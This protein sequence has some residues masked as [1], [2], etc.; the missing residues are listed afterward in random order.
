MRCGEVGLACMHALPPARQVQ[1]HAQV[2]RRLTRSRDASF[3]IDRS[4]RTVAFKFPSDSQRFCCI[5]CCKTFFNMLGDVT[6]AG[7]F[8]FYYL[9]LKTKTSL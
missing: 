2:V 7:V 3:A 5:I 9:I 6:N 4:E 8:N 1:V